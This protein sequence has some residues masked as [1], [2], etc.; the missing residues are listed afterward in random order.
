MNSVGANCQNKGTFIHEFSIQYCSIIYP[1]R[2]HDKQKPP[3]A[4][5]CHVPL[6]AFY[7]P[8]KVLLICG[9]SKP[10]NFIFSTPTFVTW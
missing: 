7:Q 1:T 9:T 5:G 4:K 8:V 2:L 10:D 3:C 6:A